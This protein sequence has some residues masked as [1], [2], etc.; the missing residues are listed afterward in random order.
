MFEPGTNILT[1]QAR[2]ANRLRH[3]LGLT[4]EAQWIATRERDAARAEVERLRTA[5]EVHRA[6]WE[7]LREPGAAI[8]QEL[9]AVLEMEGDRA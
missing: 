8:D 3:E 9:Y 2:E 6:H 7:P 5:I 1:E 4:Q